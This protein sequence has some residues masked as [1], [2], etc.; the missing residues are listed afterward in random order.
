MI[1]RTLAPFVLLPFLLPLACVDCAPDRRLS[2]VPPECQQPHTDWPWYDIGFQAAV[3]C[4]PPGW[5]GPVFRLKADYPIEAPVD[6][7]PWA[8]IDFTTQP[9]EYLAALLDYALDDPRLPI[10]RRET[11]DVPMNGPWYHAPWLNVGVHGREF[12]HGL[13]RERTSLPGELHHRQK[14]RFQNWA[15]SVFDRRGG[16]ALGRIWADRKSPKADVAFPPNTYAIKFLFTEAPVSQVPYL[17][18]A[19]EWRAHIHRGWDRAWPGNHERSVRTV[20]LLQVDVAVKDERQSDTGAG[21][22]FGTFVYHEFVKHCD[23]WRR[24]I[25][26]GLAWGNSTGGKLDGDEQQYWINPQAEKLLIAELTGRELRESFGYE[27]R[28]N[29]MVDNPGSSCLSCHGS[30]QVVK[31]E[32][33]E[34]LGCNPNFGVALL[35]PPEDASKSESAEWFGNVKSGTAFV[36]EKACIPGLGGPKLVAANLQSTDYSLQVMFGI[37]RFRKICAREGTCPKSWTRKC[38]LLASQDLP[39]DVGPDTTTAQAAQSASNEE[40]AGAGT[41]H[42]PMVTEEEM[43]EIRDL[44]GPIAR[45]GRQ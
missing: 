39:S 9:K 10:D 13:T 16:Y 25:P 18:G 11:G 37:E 2:E 43:A 34:R 33:A 40:V 6:R 19:P 1:R 14:D 44:E 35:A 7:V 30:A 23:P 26:V 38:D 32:V 20:R 21:W 28:L 41:A 22:V 45:E 31:T 36:P 29:G 27:G 42:D 15:V 24:L 17:Q 12:V 3:H 4:P 8:P 5:T